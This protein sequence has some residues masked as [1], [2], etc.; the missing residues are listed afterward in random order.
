MSCRDWRD[1][2]FR[3]DVSQAFLCRD[4]GGMHAKN[5]VQRCRDVAWMRSFTFLVK[6]YLLPQIWYHIVLFLFKRSCNDHKA[7]DTICIIYLLKPACCVSF[8]ILWRRLPE[9]QGSLLGTGLGVCCFASFRMFENH[10]LELDCNFPRVKSTVEMRLSV[11]FN[12]GAGLWLLLLH[13]KTSCF[14]NSACQVQ[15]L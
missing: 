11:Q 6:K 3:R 12:S 14:G 15:L 2:K 13:F 5:I 9:R 4:S 8:K 7:V 1:T 10:M